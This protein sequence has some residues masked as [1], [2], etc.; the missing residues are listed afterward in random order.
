MDIVTIKKNTKGL[1]EV[2]YLGK[3]IIEKSTLNR[4]TKALAAYVKGLS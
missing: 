1:Y 2:V 3:Q 4:A